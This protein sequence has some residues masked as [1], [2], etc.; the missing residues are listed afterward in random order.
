MNFLE[1]VLGKNNS[2]WRYAATIVVA[3][4]ASNFIGAIP[5]V[6]VLIVQCVKTG[7]DLSL[8]NEVIR[9]PSMVGISQNLYLL[10]FM[11]A[12]VVALITLIL[13]IKWLH[14]RSFSETINGTKRVRWRRVFTGFGVWFLLSLFLLMASYFIDPGDL[15]FQFDIRSFIPLFFIA[16][17]FIPLQITFEEL[18]FRGY[19]AQ[20][21]G[22]WTKNRW[23][24]VFIPSILFGLMHSWNT[25]VGTYGFWASMPQYVLFGLIFGFISVLDDGIELSMGFHAAN[26]IFACLFVT[27][28]GSSLKTPALFH[29]QTVNMHHETITLLLFGLIVFIFFAKKYKWNLSV[30]NKKVGGDEICNDP[31]KIEDDSLKI[32]E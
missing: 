20:G 10:L 9:D 14:R 30:M 27:F 29:Q 8:M 32:K 24:A 25:E 4:L 19:L 22:A 23:L 16:L 3:F 26:N 2:F 13:L 15:T 17:I 28:D 21:I 7:V 6:T 18:L 1:N 5:L 31:Q 11:F 12:F